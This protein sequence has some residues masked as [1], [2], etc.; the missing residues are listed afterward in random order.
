MTVG[1]NT[2]SAMVTIFEVSP[3]PSQ[4][5]SSGKSAIFGIGN[6]ADTIGKPAARANENRPTASPT[7]MPI[8]VPM[9]QPAPIRISDIEICAHNSPDAAIR[10]SARMIASGLGRKSALTRPSDPAACHAA[11]TNANTSHEVVPR[12]AG[13]NPVARTR[14]ACR[15]AGFC[16]AEAGGGSTETVSRIRDLPVGGEPPL[17]HQRPRPG[18]NSAKLRLEAGFVARTARYGNRDDVLDPSGTRREHDD[19]VGEPEGLVEIMGDVND[20]EIGAVEEPH[21]IL[22]QQ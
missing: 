14:T 6:R 7:E 17:A 5:M 4:R 21:Q 20:G 18:V 9:T 10:H 11:S 12:G 2:P 3:I 15:A 13:A 1:K 8:A 22:D 19:A 16:L